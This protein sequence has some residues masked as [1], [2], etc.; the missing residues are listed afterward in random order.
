MH[1]LKDGVV[2]VEDYSF[3]AF[4]R[5]FLWIQITIESFECDPL[6][7]KTFELSAANFSPASV[8]EGRPGI[9]HHIVDSAPLS[10]YHI[11]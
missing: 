3:R 1:V 2:L 4:D 7:A 5:H 6:L 9:I 8:T 10:K 11:F